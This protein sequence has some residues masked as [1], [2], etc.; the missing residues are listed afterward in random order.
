MFLKNSFLKIRD[1]FNITGDIDLY[2]ER[3]GQLFAGP[4]PLESFKFVHG[5]I[6]LAF[7]SGLILHKVLPAGVA[8]IE[9]GQEVLYFSYFRVAGLSIMRL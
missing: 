3:S 9:I 8:I 6:N 4:G 5:F 1:F 2:Q 7:E